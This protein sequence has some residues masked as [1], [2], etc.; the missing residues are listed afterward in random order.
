MQ[1]R[2]IRKII[3]VQICDFYNHSFHRILEQVKSEASDKSDP[4][5]QTKS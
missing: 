4:D 2:E 3:C 1:R 5:L